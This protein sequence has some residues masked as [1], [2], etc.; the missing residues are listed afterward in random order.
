MFRRE[1]PPTPPSPLAVLFLRFKIYNKCTIGVDQLWNA[2]GGAKQVFVSNIEA[3]MTDNGD[4]TYSYSYTPN[5]SGEVTVLV[6]LEDAPG[7]YAEHFANTGWSGD[8]AAVQSFTNINTNWG[9]GDIY[10]GRPNSVSSYFYTKLKAPVTGTYSFSLGSD[11]GSDLILDGVTKVSKAGTGCIWT[12]SF[13]A[14]LTA[15]QLYLL[16]IKHLEIGGGAFLILS[17]SYPGQAMTPIPG[18]FIIDNLGENMFYTLPVGNTPYQVISSCPTGYIGTDVS[19]PYNWVFD[20][21]CGDGIV[22]GSEAWD[23]GGTTNGDGWNSDCTSVETGWSWTGGSPTTQST[24]DPIWGDGKL[25]G[26]EVWDD[27]NTAD[28]DGCK[29]DCTAVETGWTWSGGTT[30]TKSVCDPIWGDGLLLGSEIWDDGNTV[31]GDGW[32]GSCL[33]IEIG[34]SWT[35]GSPTTQSTWTPIWG[36]GMLYGGEIC[37]DQNTLDGDGCNVDCTAVETGWTCSGGSTITKSAWIPIWGDG[38]VLGYEVWDDSNTV[39]GD[40]WSSNWLNVETGWVW[41]GGGSTTQSTWSPVWGDGKVI[42]DELCDDGDTNDGEGCSA[43]WQFINN[44]WICNGGTQTTPDKCE[45]WISGYTHNEDHSKWIVMDLSAAG[46]VMQAATGAVTAG[47]TFSNLLSSF[48]SQSSPQSAFSSINQIQLLLLLLLVKAYLP[49]EVVLYLRSI[50]SSLISFDFNLER[51][52]G[53]SIIYDYFDVEQPDKRLELLHL[54]SGS[55][56]I[57]ILETIIIILSISAIHVWIVLPAHLFISKKLKEGFIRRIARG[58][59]KLFTFSIYIGYF[60]EAYLILLM[61]SFSE[62][63]RFKTSSSN[64]FNSL[65]SAFFICV[66]WWAAFFSVVILWKNLWANGSKKWSDELF[67][68]LRENKF[69]KMFPILFL[70]RRTV[71]WGIIMCRFQLNL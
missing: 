71:L 44:K 63:N 70:A 16:K 25:Y 42:G 28:N 65:F 1:I 8:P 45:K 59:F 5:Q 11:D 38:L 40:G 14:T 69:W 20:K 46:Q 26:D 6:Y 9:S 35:G 41:N 4:G 56:I 49:D 58:I 18:K 48:F 62:T 32:E 51:V 31:G 36:D 37:D 60:F 30:T 52:F 2:V 12:D 64:D 61:V 15:G 34:W 47:S 39:S 54:E 7:V 50:S 67:T 66:F 23:D 24:C 33:S 53:F 57:N 19:S 21:I 68:G 29:G 10:P 27:Q 55:T 43:N 13:S 3:T 17:W 22:T